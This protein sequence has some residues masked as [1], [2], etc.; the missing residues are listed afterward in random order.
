MAGFAA[1]RSCRGLLPWSVALA[2]LLGRGEARAV[3]SFTVERAA[4]AESCPNAESIAV[5]IEAIRGKSAP[6]RAEYRVTFSLAGEEFAASI[7]AGSPGQ[8]RTILS[9]RPTCVALGE[10]T[11][12]TLALLFD[13]DALEEAHPPE[14]APPLAAPVV[15]VAVPP[16][17]LRGASLSVGAAGL[18]GALSSFSLA[19]IAEAD[20]A[21][22]GWRAGIGA[23]WALPQTQTLGP[24]NVREE[25]LSGL[26]RVCYS[27]LQR[28]RARVDL[29]SGTYVGAMTG[30]A[31][32]FSTNGQRT[33]LWVAL[34]AELVLAFTPARHLGWELSA[35]ALWQLHRSDFGIDGLG[36]AYRSPV[37]AGLVSLRAVALLSW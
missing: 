14:S 34:P 24:G 12:V 3:P 4:G 31:S 9:R 27:P 29:C 21:M 33:R 7:T 17:G 23:L 28:R 20:G 13:S 10:A 16:P 37:V 8:R 36:V 22:G 11:A 2:L 1:G 6:R 19:G 35:G 30:D 18:V 25:I 15:T 32:G 26:L 5:R